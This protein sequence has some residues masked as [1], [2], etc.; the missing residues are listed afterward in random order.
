[1][2][3]ALASCQQCGS[4]VSI[5]GGTAICMECGAVYDVI[6]HGRGSRD[7]SVGPERVVNAQ[8]KTTEMNNWVMD[9]AGTKTLHDTTQFIGTV[10]L[11]RANLLVVNPDG[12]RS[13][14]AGKTVRI[15]RRLDTGL[16]SEVGR[17]TTDSSGL[18][19]IKYTLVDEGKNAFQAIF[20]GDATYYGCEKKT[21]GFNVGDYSVGPER[22]VEVQE[23]PPLIGLTVVVKDMIF[24][25]PIEGAKVV[26]DMNEALTD[27]SGMAV[28][29]TLSPGT[30]ALSVSA[31]DYK[32]ET[33]TVDLT[34]AGM[35]VEVGLWH[36]GAI[37][38][39]LVGG[40]S[41]GLIVA[42]KALKRG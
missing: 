37:A 31:R 3:N 15:N 39:G 7:F 17:G 30:Y 9:E 27:A 10:V 26:I 38:L 12:S 5:E 41:V 18:V 23:Q 2:V 8:K 32:S 22:F 21:D 20:D 4:A 16:P 33:R 28:F 40:A 11:L 42:H 14:L 13:N 1:M 35:V 25:K 29:D 6:R 36:I 19:N 24:K 34:S